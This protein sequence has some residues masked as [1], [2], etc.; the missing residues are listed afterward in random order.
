MCHVSPRR[1]AQPIDKTTLMRAARTAWEAEGLVVA[2]D[3][4]AAV[5]S[6]NPTTESHAP[7]RSGSPGPAPP[8]GP[9]AASPW[10]GLGIGLAGIDVLVLKE[11]NL[12]DDRDRA[13]LDRV[14]REAGTKV[15][16]VCD[17]A[18]AP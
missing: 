8:S 9:I 18:A 6:Q 4:T 16:E 10:A 3:A 1:R 12:T 15:V 14:A 11:A 7:S 5:A 17:P 13:T 2:G